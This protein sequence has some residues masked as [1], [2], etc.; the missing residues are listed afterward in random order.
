MPFPCGSGSAGVTSDPELRRGAGAYES[1]TAFPCA[2]MIVA[3]YTCPEWFLV[4]GANSAHGVI[5]GHPVLC[6]WNRFL[7]YSR[8]GTPPGRRSTF[9]NLSMNRSAAASGHL[10]PL[11]PADCSDGV[12]SLHRQIGRPRLA[13]RQNKRTRPEVTLEHG[14][15]H[16]QRG[17]V[18]HPSDI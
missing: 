16:P 17:P 2:R 14:H 11:P 12:P 4:L 9:L 15:Y 10:N 6:L 3:K 13:R 5:P 18:R 8:N 7:R 1:L